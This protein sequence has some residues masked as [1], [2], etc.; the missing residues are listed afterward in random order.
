[1]PERYPDEIKATSP[2]SQGGYSN[3]VAITLP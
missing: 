2:I 3:G 1:M